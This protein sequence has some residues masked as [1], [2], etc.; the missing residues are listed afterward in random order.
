MKS[1][2]TRR[3]ERLEAERCADNVLEGARRIVRACD[4]VEYHP[5][6]GSPRCRRQKE[7]VQVKS[8]PREPLFRWRGRPQ[9]VAATLPGRGHGSTKPLAGS[10]TPTAVGYASTRSDFQALP[11]GPRRFPPSSRDADQRHRLRRFDASTEGIPNALEPQRESLKR[12]SERRTQFPSRSS[13][14]DRRPLRGRRL[15]RAGQGLLAAGYWRGLLAKT[16]VLLN[17]IIDGWSPV[18]R[19]SARARSCRVGAASGRNLVRPKSSPHLRRMAE[20]S[21]G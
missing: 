5:E 3:V 21:Q 4:A 16:T 6:R 20:Q 7:R 18:C 12:K 2:L 13:R 9:K 11:N 10:R 1:N 8:V 19:T 17:P 14:R 15:P